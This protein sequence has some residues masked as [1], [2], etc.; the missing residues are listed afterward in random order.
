MRKQVEKPDR[1]IARIAAR[2]HGIVDFGQ[3]RWAGLVPSAIARRVRA[4]HLHR[5]YRG[6][7]AVGHTD[8][9]REG[10]WFAAVRACGPGAVLSHESAAHL[11]GLSPK[12][13]ATI[14]VTV[15][16]SNGRRRR[17]GIRLHYSTTLIA[18]DVARRKNIP[19]TTRA[20]TLADL[21]WG[22]EPT[23]SDLER[24]FLRLCKEHGIPKPEVN[25]KVGPYTVD[26]LWRAERLVVE[27]DGYR[28]RSDRATFRSDRAR[29][30][31]LNRRGFELLR[32]A[33]VELDEEP[34][35]VVSSVKDHLRQRSPNPSGSPSASSPGAGLA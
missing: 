31:E 20:R 1:I 29:G 28:Y 18:A 35:A 9:S 22:S 15:P 13:P 33:D 2:Q 23:R 14:H 17:R 30:R 5:L 21:G 4:G 26:F 19:V 12:S 24:A 3:L 34:L 6:V 32:F 7:Y 11:W 10:R 16:S 27:V 8:L 25:V